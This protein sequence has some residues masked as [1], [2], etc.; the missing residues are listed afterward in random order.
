MGNAFSLRA[1]TDAV[2]QL[3]EVGLLKRVY[4]SVSN[5]WFFKILKKTV[6]K[7]TPKS[8][9]TVPPK[10]EDSNKSHNKKENN[11][12]E[13]AIIAWI[14]EVIDTQKEIEF[15][16]KSEWAQ[17]QINKG[18]NPPIMSLP[19]EYP[20]WICDRTLDTILNDNQAS[21]ETN[22]WL[23]SFIAKLKERLV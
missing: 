5:I 19:N 15:W 12:K 6:G 3:T 11:N 16:K 2:K 8:R 9:T 1:I 22:K 23:K 13:M 14:N 18:V 10:K 21:P 17:N 4:D 20:A 7:V